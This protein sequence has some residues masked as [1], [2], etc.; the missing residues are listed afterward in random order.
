MEQNT[1]GILHCFYL[2]QGSPGSPNGKESAY[3]CRR[4]KRCGFDPWVRKKPW[5]KK[6]KPT[7]VFWPR[8]F[9][10]L[11]SPWGH[12]ESDTTEW[13]SLSLSNDEFKIYILYTFSIMY[14]IKSL[15]LDTKWF[16]VLWWTFVCLCYI[17][18][19]D[20]RHRLLNGPKSFKSF[21]VLSKYP[22]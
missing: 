11:C 10:G 12:K 6:W 9:H 14:I 15:L 8:E 21:H 1:A 18:M 19:A 13:L 20:S 16:S 17:L 4:H 22:S 7:P 2:L 3:Q 5:R